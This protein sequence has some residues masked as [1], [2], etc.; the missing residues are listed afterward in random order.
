MTTIHLYIKASFDAIKTQWWLFKAFFT[1]DNDDPTDHPYNK[2][3]PIRVR[4][5]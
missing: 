2:M 5:K 3:T 4:V 1:T